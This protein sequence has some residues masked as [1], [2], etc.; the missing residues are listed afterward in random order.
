MILELKDIFAEDL[1]LLDK[2]RDINSS[3]YYLVF[4]SFARTRANRGKF[5]FAVYLVVKSLKNS[6][7]SF[8]KIDRDLIDII[9]KRLDGDKFDC[10]NVDLVDFKNNLFVYKMK[11]TRE[12]EI[13]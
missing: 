3:G 6:Q 4:E 12:K 10:Q 7:Q 8:E 13:I 1:V 9:T 5:T 2:Q 11:L